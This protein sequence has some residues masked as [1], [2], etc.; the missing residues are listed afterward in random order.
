MCMGQ[1]TALLALYL[2]G[3]CAFNSHA[4]RASATRA[5]PG[6]RIRVCDAKTVRAFSVF[7]QP[8]LAVL[9]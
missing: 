1:T 5:K 3:S 9:L 8:L 2:V 7:L 4:K 6:L